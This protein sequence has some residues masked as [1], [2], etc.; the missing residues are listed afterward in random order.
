MM[1]YTNAVCKKEVGEV[2]PQIMQNETDGSIDIETYYEKEFVREFLSRVNE[3]FLLFIGEVRVPNQV[4][5][6][7][8][9]FDMP[10]VPPKS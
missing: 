8:N 5:R 3:Q 7:A 2:V 4:V 9:D 10:R 6:M 1:G